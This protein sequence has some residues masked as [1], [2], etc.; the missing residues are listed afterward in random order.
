MSEPTNEQINKTIHERRGLCWHVKIP[1]QHYATK[2]TKC[3][4]T[5]NQSFQT[6]WDRNP[7]YTA[8]LNAVHE[9]EIEIIGNKKLGKSSI[10]QYTD[11]L[12]KLIHAERVS[13][14]NLGFFLTIAD[15]KHRA[16]AIYNLIKSQE[17]ENV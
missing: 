16:R 10:W 5:V 13:G 17:K 14:L 15:A 3:G 7:D 8:D 2:C 11:E 4:E 9:A 12:E 6:G 1:S